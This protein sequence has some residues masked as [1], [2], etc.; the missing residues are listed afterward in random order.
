MNSITQLRTHLLAVLRCI[1]VERMLRPGTRLLLGRG[2][3][4]VSVDYLVEYSKEKEKE[5]E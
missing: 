4:T 2:W 1:L 3:K 5:N